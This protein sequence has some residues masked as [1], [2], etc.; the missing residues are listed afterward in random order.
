MIPLNATD[1]DLEILIRQ[2]N[3]DIC[4]Q[5]ARHPNAS[6]EL[7]KRLFNQYCLD[8][9]ANPALELILLENPN[10]LSDLHNRTN[11]NCFELEELPSFIYKI[12]VHHRDFWFRKAI[13]LNSSTPKYILQKLSLDPDIEVRAA[14]ALNEN[15][16]VDEMK[17]LVLAEQSKVIDFIEAISNIREYYFEFNDLPLFFYDIAVKA[18]DSSEDMYN[19]FCIEIAGNSHTP[20]HILEELSFSQDAEVRAEV[21]FN[22]NTPI[23]T[24]EKLALD[25]S[26]EVIAALASNE[27]LS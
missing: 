17:K 5:V 12:A 18:K 21:A 24:L 11:Y 7:L 19:W 23:H 27:N 9:L 25:K 13:A 2:E 20:P 4:Q 22:S 15:T 1:K 16:A 3:P 10:F 14:V 6:P 8:V 26:L